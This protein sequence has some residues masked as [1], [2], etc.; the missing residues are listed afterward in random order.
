MLIPRITSAMLREQPDQ[1]VKVIN[2][3]IGVKADTT[4]PEYIWKQIIA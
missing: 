2:S 3:L 1:T 4:T